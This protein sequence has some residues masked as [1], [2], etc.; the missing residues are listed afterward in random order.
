LVA[1]V[2]AFVVIVVVN[3]VVHGLLLGGPHH[4]AASAFRQEA[5]AQR[6]FWL[7]YVGYLVF[8]FL[9]LA[10]LTRRH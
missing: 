10:K 8:A 7:F 6:L 1:S 4:R 5:D 2:A 9:L 3:F